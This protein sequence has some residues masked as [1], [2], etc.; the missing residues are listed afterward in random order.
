MVAS[1]NAIIQEKKETMREYVKRFTRE[2][3]EVKGFYDKLKC[4]ILKK[5][6][7]DMTEL[8]TRAQPC[9]NYEEKLWE[10]KVENDKS[11][12][13]NWD[14]KHREDDDHEKKGRHNKFTDFTP[15]NTER[16]GRERIL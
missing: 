6:F 8:L 16:G 15:R 5:G 10:A 9:I 1:L 3:V 7:Y 12:R 2:V 14:Q 4:Y 11:S 13:K